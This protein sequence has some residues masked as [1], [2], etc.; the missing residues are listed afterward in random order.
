[1]VI[2]EN[3]VMSWRQQVCGI[4]VGTLPLLLLG[5]QWWTDCLHTN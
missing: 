2:V 4:P 1:M 5:Y 3:V